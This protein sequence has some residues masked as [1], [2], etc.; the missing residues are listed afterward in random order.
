M[1][2]KPWQNINGDGNIH[3]Y[4][5]A[6]IYNKNQIDNLIT[7]GNNSGVLGVMIGS[8][9]MW[10][11]NDI[12]KGWMLCDGTLLQINQF[13]ELYSII[14]TTYGGDGIVTF[15]LPDLQGNVP[16]GSNIQY[17]IGA[18]GGKETVTLTVENLPEHNHE[19]SIPAS[20]SNG[21]LN[22]PNENVIFATGMSNGRIAT[23]YSILEPDKSLKAFN[24]SLSG[25]NQSF[26]I[27]QPYLSLNFIIAVEGITPT[28]E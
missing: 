10:L 26:N 3:Q 16:L 27:M 4:T 22:E 12:P 14:G 8:V 23:I 17:T 7:G 11:S 28:F 18:K 1:W 19:V 24:T 20:S 2:S 21:N 13:S 25:S 6:N 15:A 5:Y 9:M